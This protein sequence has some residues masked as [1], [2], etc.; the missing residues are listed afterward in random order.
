VRQLTYSEVVGTD[1]TK[2][3]AIAKKLMVRR[4]SIVKDGRRVPRAEENLVLAVNGEPWPLCRM[5]LP[6]LLKS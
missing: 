4:T 3:A 5:A 2:L 1:A 6:S